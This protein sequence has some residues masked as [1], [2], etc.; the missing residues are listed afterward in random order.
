MV[1]RGIDLKKELLRRGHEVTEVYPYA[2]KV[3]LFGKTLPPKTRPSGVKALRE[4]LSSLIPIPAPEQAKLTHDL[5]DAVIAAYT[6]YLQHQGLAELIGDPEEGLISIPSK[7]V[8]TAK[9]WTMR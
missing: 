7:K 5:C 4:R 2:S 6:A 8:I 1:A 9:S 3:R